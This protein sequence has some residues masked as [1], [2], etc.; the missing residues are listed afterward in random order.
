MG[1]QPFNEP[2]K[3]ETEDDK[4]CRLYRY[5]KLLAQRFPFADSELMIDAS[6][7]C[8]SHFSSTDEEEAEGD[9]IQKNLPENWDEEEVFGGIK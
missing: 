7:D 6:R 9:F 4:L 2:Y 1:G 5:R 3:V 8:V